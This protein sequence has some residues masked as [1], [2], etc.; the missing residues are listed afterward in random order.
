MNN[1]ILGTLGRIPVIYSDHA[2]NPKYE[3]IKRSWKE[4][5]FTKPWQPKRKYK[6]VMVELNPQMYRVNI[7]GRG[8]TIVA[9]TSL[10]DEI[11]R[12]CKS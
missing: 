1:G 3:N 9:H 4:R 6:N 8:L 11:V 5:L 10:H 7:P 12:A 2:C